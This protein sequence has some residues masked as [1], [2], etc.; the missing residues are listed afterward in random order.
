MPLRRAE[1]ELFFL[2]FPLSSG[3]RRET[4]INLIFLMLFVIFAL[5]GAVILFRKKLDP[6]AHRLD[7]PDPILSRLPYMSPLPAPPGV[8]WVAPDRTQ[9]WVKSLTAPVPTLSSAPPGP[10]WEPVISKDHLLQVLAVQPQ[11]SGTRL[12]LLLWTETPDAPPDAYKVTVN[13]AVVPIAVAKP[14][15]L[16]P[17]V[18][19]E[20][21]TSGFV[22]PPKQVLLL[23]VTIPSPLPPCARIDLT[24]PRPES[25]IHTSVNLPTRTG[26]LGPRE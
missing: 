17:G 26:E 23:D 16:P 3:V 4:R 13:D 10:G 18:R 25:P 21:V 12:T 1:P 24:Y 5:P 15:M 19:R 20:L 9:A 6:T 11:D 8:K 22:R 14:A 7:Q 2:F